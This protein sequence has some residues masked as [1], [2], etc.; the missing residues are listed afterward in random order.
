[1]RNNHLGP[2]ARHEQHQTWYKGAGHPGSWSSGAHSANTQI[3]VLLRKLQLVGLNDGSLLV[4]L[5]QTANETNALHMRWS[6]D[7]GPLQR[8][9]RARWVLSSSLISLSAERPLWMVTGM[10]FPLQL[11]TAVFQNLKLAHHAAK[12][13]KRNPSTCSR[14]QHRT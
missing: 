13:G 5:L 10:V 6:L 8:T 7:W 11:H 12:N 1:M 2:P 4:G 14:L 3:N 9:K